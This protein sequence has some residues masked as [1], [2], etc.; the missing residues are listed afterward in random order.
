MRNAR[1]IRMRSYSHASGQ[2]S[3]EIL[4]T[5]RNFDLISMDCQMP[6]IDGFETT[7]KITEFEKINNQQHIPI[8]ALTG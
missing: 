2:R 4:K 3:C 7:A 5:D 8:I 6:M 1:K